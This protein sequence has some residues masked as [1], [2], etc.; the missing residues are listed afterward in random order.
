[1]ENTAGA[2]LVGRDGRQAM[3]ESVTATGDLRG[4][5]LDMTVVQRFRNTGPT[6]M[7]VVYR[8]P[9]PWAAVLLGMDVTLNG[10]HLTGSVIEKRA[11]EARYEEALSQG[12]SAIMLER[13]PDGSYAVNLGNLLAGEDCEIR[14]RYAQLLAF[15]QGGLRLLIPTVIAP[16]YGDPVRDGGLAPHQAPQVDLLAVYPFD[17]L[18]RLHGTLAAARV[19]SPSHPIAVGREPANGEEVLAVSLARQ[20]ALDRDFVLVVDRLA[21]P[22]LTLLARDCVADPASEQVVVL[23][24][25]LPQ[26]PARTQPQ[27][28]KVLVDCSGS[29][30]GDSIAAARRALLALIRQ[31]AAGDRFSL[32]RFGSTVEHR[33]RGLWSLTPATQRTAEHWI[34]ALQADLGGTEM[35]EALV[36]TC[37]LPHEGDTDLLLVTDGEIEAIEPLIETA[38]T[39]GHRVFVVGIG[40]S[41]A[42]GHLRRLAA[43][44]GGACDFVAPGEA[45]EPAV[46][47]MFAR[48]RSPG[49]APRNWSGQ[50][51]N[52]R[53]GYRPWRLRCSLG[54]R[55]MRLP[56]LPNG[57]GGRS[58]CSAWP[59]ARASPSRWPARSLDRA[60]AWSQAI[61]CPA[62]PP[63]TAS[64]PYRRWTRWRRWTRPHWRSPISWSRIAPIF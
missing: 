50:K 42:E 11:A 7:E 64:W 8:F 51:A 57:P 2:R 44:T 23:A 43:A 3:L 35:R 34:G 22:S 4:L 28:L 16:R 20:G 33:S 25:F 54:I 21:Q 48:L 39:S 49:S 14:L 45:V 61:P 38:R 1:M 13:N 46:L 40:A 10:Q 9:L 27:A 26:L 30:G 12:H 56:A 41:P 24:S 36:S 37:A 29:M 5:V 6:N 63:W 52:P 31:L 32:S 15:E 17:L 62:S 18:L 59:R 55:S 58:G 19:A 60:T 47:R 53:S